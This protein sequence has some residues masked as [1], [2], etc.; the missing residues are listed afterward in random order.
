MRRRANDDEFRAAIGET[1]RD[2]ILWFDAQKSKTRLTWF[3]SVISCTIMRRVRS[4]PRRKSWIR[5]GCWERELEFR[6]G[7][8]EQPGSKTAIHFEENGT[9]MLNRRKPHYVERRPPFERIALLLQGG[10]ALGSYQA[11]VYQA[12]AEANLHPDWIAG[13]SIGAVNS[14]LI[15]GNPP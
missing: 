1:Y 13:I 7:I 12:L 10:G 2:N 6:L 4:L 11:G 8:R 14:A 15:A 3:A 5:R 9:S